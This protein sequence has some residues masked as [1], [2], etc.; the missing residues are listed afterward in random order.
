MD[1]GIFADLIDLVLPVSCVCCL[2]P[3]QAWCAAC[4]PGVLLRRVELASGVPT[5]SAGSYGATLRTA[6]LA[7]KER[8]RRQ[9]AIPLGQL[10]AAAVTAVVEPGTRPWLVTIP[11][12]RAA[13]RERGGDHVRRLA[14]VVAR[15]QGLDD[16]AA[17]RLTGSVRDS[18]GLSTDERIA[19]LDG[20]MRAW[21]P[22]GPASAAVLLDDIV[23][24]G[25]TI[26]EAHRAM[27]AAGWRVM[28]AATVAATIRRWPQ[29]PIL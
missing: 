16:R 5:V 26:T 28:G 21:P 14:R 17:L 13:A 11:S 25:A 4:N 3:G 7:Y 27:T 1:V 2:S 18:A 24:T 29:G 8:G 22:P 10:L 19:N 12:R 6:L 15:R 23:T 20:R 9:L